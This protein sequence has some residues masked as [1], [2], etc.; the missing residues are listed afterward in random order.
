MTAGGLNMSV[1]LLT[2]ATHAEDPVAG[3]LQRTP[4]ENLGS[5][6][7]SL[8]SQTINAAFAALLT[9][10]IQA[11]L[12]TPI[13][14]RIC[15]DLHRA[16][17]L[18]LRLLEQSL[19]ATQAELAQARTALVH[20]QSE[21]MTA[22]HMALHDALTSLPNRNCFCQQLSRSLT[23]AEASRDAFAV[24][25]LDLDGFKSLN[26]THGHDTGDELLRIVAERLAR[27]VRAEDMVSRI[28]GD[29]FAC[30]LTGMCCQEQLRH[31]AQT[32]FET[33]AAPVQIGALDLC[34]C[35]SIGIAT[36]PADGATT[37]AL[38]KSADAAMYRAK[39][40]N[41]R[42]AFFD[43]QHRVELTRPG[44]VPA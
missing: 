38:L 23:A 15:D 35:P 2:G 42:Y 37:D 29:E 7:T 31:L 10:I 13:N 28:G 34:V 6:V 27:S 21:A 8:D 11:N 25:Y 5:E 12:P 1:P 18:R 32:M 14:Q 17:S 26:D 4:I 9:H 19:S 22:R 44:N 20:A 40:Q 39:R 3:D 41:A 30:L 33:V 24:L 16:V 43:G 36:Y